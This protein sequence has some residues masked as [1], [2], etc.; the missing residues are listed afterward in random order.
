MRGAVNVE[1]AYASELVLVSAL[2]LDGLKAKCA[3]LSGF[4]E[5]APNI[6]LGDVAYTCMRDYLALRDDE[7]CKTLA[8]VTTSVSSLRSHLSGALR[9]IGRAHV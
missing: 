3:E 9:K 6:F 4:L 7:N 2:G 5:Q 8:I 1:S